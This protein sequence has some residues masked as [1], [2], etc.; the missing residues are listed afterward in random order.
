[1]PPG[2]MDAQTPASV[3][4]WPQMCRRGAQSRQGGGGPPR[5]HGV[6]SEPF[7]GGLAE[8]GQDGPFGR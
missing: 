8:T 3:C 5:R 7:R 2:A 6:L 4:E 1:M